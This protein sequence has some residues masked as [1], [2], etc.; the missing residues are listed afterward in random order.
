MPVTLAHPAAVLPLRGLGLPLSAMVIGSMVPDLPVFSRSW[1][2]YGF[3]HS[4]AGVVT[5]DLVLTLVLLSLW[6]RWGR[7]ALVDTS[8]AAVRDRLPGRARIGRAAWVLAPLAAVVGSL[9]HIVWDAFTHGGRWGVRLVPWLGEEHAGLPGHAWA[10]YGSGVVGLL[11]VGVAILAVLRRP[12]LEA[13]RPRR[14][15]AVT[16]PVA[17]LAAG[18]SS[19]LTFVSRW[20]ADPFRLAAFH[21]AVVGIVALAVVLALVTSLWALAPSR[22]SERVAPARRPGPRG[23]A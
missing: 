4:V 13:G 9:T 23:N 1:E 8:P 7:D 17:V 20:G 15:P 6:D 5:V 16:L 21:A 3:T 18:A 11:A 19:V 12:L 10:Q 22:V 2:V 14:L